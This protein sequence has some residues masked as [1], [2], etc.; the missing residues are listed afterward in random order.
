VPQPSAQELLVCVGDRP[1]TGATFV[2]WAH[3]A[4]PAA[5]TSGG[6]GAPVSEQI[7]NQVMGFLIS[8]DWVEAQAAV[9]HIHISMPEVHRSFERIRGAQFPKPGEFEKFLESS[10]QTVADLLMR[11]RLNMTS[12]RIQKRVVGARHGRAA[13]ER[14]LAQFVRAFK[15]RGEAQ[16]Y[17]LAAYATLDCGH[18][19]ASL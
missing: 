10:G 9:M 11:V 13:R 8:S 5:G 14:A 18:V 12:Q 16:T 1:I 2:H 15:R 4:E 17:C 19:L 6:S 7:L 3:V